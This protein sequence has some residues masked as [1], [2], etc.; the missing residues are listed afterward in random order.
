VSERLVS[1]V[2]SYDQVGRYGGEEF[3]IVLP[4]CDLKNAELRAEELLRIVRDEP[5]ST[6][7]GN[8]LVTVSIGVASTSSI[9]LV[10]IEKLLNY[11]DA[12]LYRAKRNGRNRLEL[13]TLESAM[14]MELVAH[15]GSEKA[16]E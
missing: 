6:P 2:R 4:G 10:P 1:G 8:R 13:A 12:A 9:G 5:V 11:A 14:S 3:V 15:S 16:A 7:N